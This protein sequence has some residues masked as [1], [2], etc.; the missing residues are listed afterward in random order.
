MEITK[1]SMHRRLLFTLVL[2]LASY[3]AHVLASFATMEEF[4][5]EFADED[6]SVKLL[7]F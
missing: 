1:N 2:L 6:G 7:F 3:I 5:L 4:L